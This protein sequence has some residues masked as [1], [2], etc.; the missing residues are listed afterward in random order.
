MNRSS[1]YALALVAGLAGA[2]PAAA[3][4]GFTLSGGVGFYSN[5]LYRGISQTTNDA[6]IQGFLE[7]SYS[8][9]DAFQIY[10]NIWGTNVEFSDA[11]VEIDVTPGIR[12]TVFG[13]LMYDVNVV[14]YWYPGANNSQDFEF[15]EP[16]VSLA[17]DFGFAVPKIG[18]RYSPEFF[19]DS[20]DAFYLYGDLSVPLNFL[21]GEVAGKP[22]AVSLFGHAGHQWIQ[23]NSTF[24]TPDYME[25]NAGVSVDV[26][27]LT[28]SIGYYDTDL[29][30]SQCFGG[31][32]YCQATVVGSVSASF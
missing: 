14:Y 15:V 12:G 22:F 25:W 7:P 17:Y 18:L 32:K 31:T 8:F 16:G 13:G 10:L 5:Y 20:G 19:A 2:A 21:S 1:Y 28:F 26:L 23:H 29:S 3:D 27:G 9:S 6:A 11:S 30:K 4:E 24:G